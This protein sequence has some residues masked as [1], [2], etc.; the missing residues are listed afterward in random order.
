MK[1]CKSCGAIQADDKTV[2]SDCGGILVASMTESE[3]QAAEQAIRQKVNEMA[4]KS[5]EF[6]I[7]RRD[8]IIS[9][10]C[11]IGIIAA[12]VLIGVAQ[13]ARVARKQEIPDFVE[14]VV[15][16]GSAITV[17]S[18]TVENTVLGDHRLKD[19]KEASGLAV[20]S[21]MIWIFVCLMLMAPRFMWNLATAK[22]RIRY[23]WDTT[24][25]AIDLR[26]RKWSAYIA[27]GI[28][29]ICLIYGWI[30]CF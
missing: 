13:H 24:P 3:E 17:P 22:Y 11:I 23:G 15:G 25:S 21:I 1:K 4:E 16:N 27:C 20:I 14:I 8:K 19:L 5:D 29:F 2:C 6:Y 10:I 30:L 26:I 9:L 28:G 18:E 12:I 7:P